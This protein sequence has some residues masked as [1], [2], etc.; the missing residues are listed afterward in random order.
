M[1]VL[2]RFT[3]SGIMD[4]LGIMTGVIIGFGMFVPIGLRAVNQMKSSQAPELTRLW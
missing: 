3:F 4:W 1:R 2:P